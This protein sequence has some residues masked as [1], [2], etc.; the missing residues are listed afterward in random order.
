MDSRVQITELKDVDRF[1]RA[2]TVVHLKRVTFFVGRVGPFYET[3]PK[4]EYS[5]AM[6][7]ARVAQIVANIP[8]GAI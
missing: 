7:E 8:P 4:D 3:F 1:D 5:L 6:L 2:G